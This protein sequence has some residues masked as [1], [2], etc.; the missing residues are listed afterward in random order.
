M[1]SKAEANNKKQWIIGCI[2]LAIIAVASSI[3]FYFLGRTQGYDNGATKGRS[4]GYDVGYSNGHDAGYQ[5]GYH[6]GE[7]HGKETGYKQGY[8]DMYD[9]AMCIITTGGSCD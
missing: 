2:I 7:Q 5:E 9:K 6:Y 1:N 4:D 3:G 8:S